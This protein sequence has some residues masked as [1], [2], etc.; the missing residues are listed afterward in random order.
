[1]SRATDADPST[2]ERLADADLVECHAVDDTYRWADE[3]RT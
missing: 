3:E 2:P 1:M